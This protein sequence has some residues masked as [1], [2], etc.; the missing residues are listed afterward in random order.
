MTMCMKDMCRWMKEF[1]NHNRHDIWTP[2]VIYELN[3][4]DMKLFRL[5]LKFERVVKNVLLLRITFLPSS[6]LCNN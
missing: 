2:Q 5:T 1:L 3:I 4:L 6:L